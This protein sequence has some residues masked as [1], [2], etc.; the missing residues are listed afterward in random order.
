MWKYMKFIFQCPQIKFY[1]DTN[2]L[3]C[4]WP[5]YG[6][7][8]YYEYMQKNLYGLKS[9]HHLLFVSLQ[10]IFVNPSYDSIFYGSI[11]HDES[12]PGQSRIDMLS[13]NPRRRTEKHLNSCGLQGMHNTNFSVVERNIHFSKKCF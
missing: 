6:L 5:F 1:W 10:K 7:W 13:L 9:L 8:S 11:F 4:L 12:V 3:I 2:A